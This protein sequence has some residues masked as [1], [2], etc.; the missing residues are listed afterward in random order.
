MAIANNMISFSTCHGVIKVNWNKWFKPHEHKREAYQ[1]LKK[2]VK[3]HAESPCIQKIKT[4][5]IIKMQNRIPN[6]ITLLS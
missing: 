6:N 1:A 3:N 4:S 2:R 5:L